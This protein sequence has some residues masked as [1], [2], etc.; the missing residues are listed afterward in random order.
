MEKTYKMPN[1]MLNMF[2]EYL[3]KN[4]RPSLE[5]FLKKY[6]KYKEYAYLISN[7]T[8]NGDDLVA[9]ARKALIDNDSIQGYKTEFDEIISRMRNINN[10]LENVALGVVDKVSF[11]RRSRVVT[12]Q[13]EFDLDIEQRKDEAI[14]FWTR[15]T[16]KSFLPGYPEQYRWG[17][18][19]AN[20][21]LYVKRGNI[22]FTN[23]TME[24][25]CCLFCEKG[26]D[27]E[28]QEEVE[29]I[30]LRPE[31]VV[32]VEEFSNKLYASSRKQNP[33]DILIK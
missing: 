2:T 11:F 15:C 13:F 10:M 12:P 33:M 3:E 6:P 20:V 21:S 27:Q 1:Y 9:L 24:T 19:Y 18:G 29:R 26:G 16:C 25:L 30:L 28:I 8:T 23:L 32:S 22:T 31:F 17:N 5:D 7:Y 4:E 14:V